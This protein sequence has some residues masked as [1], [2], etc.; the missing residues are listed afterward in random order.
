M[1]PVISAYPKKSLTNDLYVAENPGIAYQKDMS[2]SVSYDESYFENYVK[3]EGK[4]IAHKLNQNRVQMVQKLGCSQVL[5]IGIGSGEFMRNCEVAGIAAH[6]FDINEVAV[7]K[8]KAAGKF[9][10]PYAKPLPDY[11]Q[12]VTMWDAMEHM[13]RPSDLLS[14]LPNGTFVLLSLPIFLDLSLVTSSKHYKPD[15]HF[16]YYTSP[17]LI[18]FY[19]DLGYKFLGLNDGEVKAGREDVMSFSFVKGS[20]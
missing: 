8:L 6:G 3:L 18:K 16:Y 20:I 1:D 14:S 5:D 10:D 7:A 17:G 15:E 13:R 19:E 2:G 9:L 4:E 11:I 12:A